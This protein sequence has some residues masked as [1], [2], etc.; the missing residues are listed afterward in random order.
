MSSLLAHLYT[1]IKG[2]PEDVATLSLCYILENSESARHAFTN[3]ISNT[4]GITNFPK[5]HFKTQ[6]VGSNKERPDLAGYDEDN[7]ELILC[8]AKFWAGLTD[9]QPL[10][11]ID[12]LRDNGVAASKVLIFICPNARIISLWDELL[13]I[14]GIDNL[15]EKKE[16]ERYVTTIAGVHMAIVSWRSITDLL[17]QVLSSQHSTLVSDLIQLQGLCEEMDE[18][19]FLPFKPEDFGLDKAKRFL[20]YYNIVD[21]VADILKSKMSASSKGLKAT[22]QYAGYC[23]YLSYGNYGIS[24]QF[25]CINWIGLAETPFWIT[26]K[27]II[28]D[29]HWTYAKEAHEKLMSSGNGMKKKIYFND[30]NKEI[31]IPLY[32]SPYKV[33]DDVIRELYDEILSIFELLKE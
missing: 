7:N 4:L 24:V 18:Q 5:T 2:S 17:M 31:I 23:R 21:K 12:R 29:N 22:P 11:Y 25:S 6:V 16:S 8:E 10:G 27:E 15:F 30:A 14:C 9:N 19:A 32:T 28:K 3:Y 13:R 1:R 26:I 20:S 33:E